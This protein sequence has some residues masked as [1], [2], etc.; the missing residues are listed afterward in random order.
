[1]YIRKENGLIENTN[2]SELRAVRALRKR[3]KKEK[4]T[5]KALMAFKDELKEMKALLKKLDKDN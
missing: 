3:I 1:M 4:E 2:E 5:S